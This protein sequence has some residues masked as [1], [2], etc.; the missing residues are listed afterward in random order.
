M[1]H[2]LPH[3]MYGKM[4]K[5]KPSLPDMSRPA[6][7]PMDNDNKCTVDSYKTE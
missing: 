7:N 5:R 4:D 1:R 3:S 6:W 2:I